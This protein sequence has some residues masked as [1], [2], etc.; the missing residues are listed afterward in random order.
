VRA[1]ARS[2]AKADHIRSLYPGAKFE[3]A[4]VPD[5]NEDGAYDEAIQGVDG[6]LHIASPFDFTEDDSPLSATTVPA[7]KGVTNLLGAIKRK[8]PNVKRVVQMSSIASAAAI[9]GGTN[10]VDETCERT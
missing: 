6:V 4:I 3:T 5:M 7:V 1:V 9:T 2:Q 8:N 10:V